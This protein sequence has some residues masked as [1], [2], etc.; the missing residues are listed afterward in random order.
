MAGIFYS[1]KEAAEK[2]KITEKEVKKLIEQGKLRGF[3][4]GSYLLLK[5]EEVENMAGEK[6]I[7]VEPMALAEE[8]AS[9]I[10]VAPETTEPE[11]GEI[12]LSEFELLELE[13]IK[14]ESA[15]LNMSGLESPSLGKEVSAPKADVLSMKVDDVTIAQPKAASEKQR[16]AARQNAPPIKRHRQRL[17]IRRWFWKGLMEDSS[18]VIILLFL[19]LG[20]VILG[21]IALGAFL[22]KML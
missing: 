15:V 9:F 10:P 7:S 20:G 12:D 11:V 14:L 2:L 5:A 4:I 16:S 3:R 18:S 1:T 17:T 13:A 19:L 6:G 21:C 22:Y 8:Q